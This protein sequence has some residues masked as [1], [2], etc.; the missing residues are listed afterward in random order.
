MRQANSFRRS[1]VVD[2]SG[3]LNRKTRLSVYCVLCFPF[4]SRSSDLDIEISNEKHI[5]PFLVNRKKAQIWS[6]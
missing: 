6:V 2:L 5:V 3:E 4:L 1:G